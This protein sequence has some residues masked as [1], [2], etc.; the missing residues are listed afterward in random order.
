LVVWTLPD[1]SFRA[2]ELATLKRENIDW[3]GHRLTIYGK[4]GHYDAA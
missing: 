1:T 2:N 4:G 3:Q